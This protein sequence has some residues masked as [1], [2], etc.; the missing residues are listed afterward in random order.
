MTSVREFY[1]M[2]WDGT[3]DYVFSAAMKEAIEYSYAALD[4]LP[5]RKLLEVGGGYGKQALYF[6]FRGATVTVI[7]ISLESLKATEK[8][9]QQHGV[10]LAALQM[11]AEELQFP[12][13]SFD[14]VYINSLFMHVNQQKV[15]QECSRVLK[16]GGKLVIVEPLQYAPLVQA[17]RSFSSYRKM[18]PR[19]A[20]LKMFKEGKRYFS[21]YRH[22]EFYF[23]SSVLLPLFYVKSNLVHRIY[24]GVS[25]LDDFLLHFFP[26]LR[27]GCWVSVAE[28]RK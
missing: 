26:F 25:H 7:D 20:T 11:D 9:V 6:A 14:L 23:L 3:H 13:E 10:T 15:L 22:R 28:Y 1:D 17:Y 24:H 5:G 12:A 2:E 27:Y 18:K 16:R 21:E 8:L 19:Y 4:P